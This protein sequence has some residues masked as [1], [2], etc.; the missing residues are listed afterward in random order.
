MEAFQEIQPN[1][2]PPDPKGLIGFIDVDRIEL[3]MG[4]RG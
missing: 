3:A 2:L 4:Q 1:Q